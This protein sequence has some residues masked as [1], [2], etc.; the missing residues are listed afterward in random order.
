METNYQS[1]ILAKLITDFSALEF[2]NTNQKLFG[3]VAN[4]FP[5]APTTYPSCEIYAWNTRVN[6][7]TNLEDERWYGYRAISYELV[8]TSASTDIA[9]LKT[10]RLLNIQ[11][12]VLDYLEKIPANLEHAIT[13]IHV[14][15]TT[16]DQI[17]FDYVRL[18]SGIT[19]YMT[20]DF[21]L[22][23]LTLVH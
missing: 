22:K 5:Q 11:D 8:E 15:S 18:Q 6:T 9:L 23:V 2:A 10:K 12:V 14:T 3:A 16:V 4:F 13:G 21:T 19:A 1:Q 20:M 17:L 7:L